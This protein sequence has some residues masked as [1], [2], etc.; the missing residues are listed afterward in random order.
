MKK[1]I[2]LFTLFICFSVYSQS[3]NFVIDWNGT[4][5]LSTESSRV[6]VPFFNKENFNYSVS[7]GL[8][9]FSQWKTDALM[10]VLRSTSRSCTW[11]QSRCPAP[12]VIHPL[13]TIHRP[14]VGSKA[15]GRSESRP[16]WEL[17][18]FWPLVHPVSRAYC[19]PHST[20]ARKQRKETIEQ[21][22]TAR[23]ARSVVNVTA[24][25]TGFIRP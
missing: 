23:A 5:I 18:R 24:C 21:T 4:K 14:S 7:D 19:C 3:N 10:P 16:K 11:V 13:E 1:N 9:F 8:V 6:E 20:L 12:R 25:T 15:T 17:L 2:F 22:T